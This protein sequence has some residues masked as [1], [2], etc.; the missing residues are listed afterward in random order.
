MVYYVTGSLHVIYQDFFFSVSIRFIHI[1]KLYAQFTVFFENMVDCYV[2]SYF[3]LNLLWKV[4]VVPCYSCSKI[5]CE[6][7]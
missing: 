5:P 1:Y 7:H 3:V 6:W 4:F 2:N